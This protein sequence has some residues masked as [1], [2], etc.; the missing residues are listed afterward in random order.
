MSANRVALLLLES[1]CTDRS[2]SALQADRA[3]NT[4]FASPMMVHR[5]WSLTSGMSND[6]KARWRM[7]LCSS[8]KVGKWCPAAKICIVLHAAQSWDDAACR[9]LRW[10]VSLDSVRRLQLATRPRGRRRVWCVS[11]FSSACS[12]LAGTEARCKVLKFQSLHG[13][14]PMTS[15]LESTEAQASIGVLRTG[16]TGIL[17]PWPLG[18][19]G[20]WEEVGTKAMLRT[21]A[22]YEAGA[23]GAGLS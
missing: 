21:D 8:H 13:Q 5:F 18:L 7:A 10:P 12:A 19:G 3:S 20:R 17:V 2:A 4:N 11:I 16:M 15:A 22:G 9:V 14:R 6:I 1:L 23:T